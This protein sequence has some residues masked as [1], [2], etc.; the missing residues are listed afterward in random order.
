M[1]AQDMLLAAKKL[2]IE[3][4]GYRANLYRD[5]LGIQTIGVG[6]NIDQTPMR[7]DEIQ[8]RLTNDITYFYSSLMQY[9]WFKHL[10]ANR[11]L[12]IIDMAFMGI[13]RLLGFTKMIIALGFG[14][15][16]E[17]ASEALNSKWAQ[18]VGKRAEDVAN[19]LRTGVLV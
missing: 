10:D 8:L 12:A 14:H 17:A 2:L 13:K 4:E 1:I 15:Y 19:I 3:H 7:D 9:D 5:S 6:W 11:Q 18:Q 16:D